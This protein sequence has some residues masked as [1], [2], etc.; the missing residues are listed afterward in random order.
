MPEKKN[1]CLT[2][3]SLSPGGAEKQCLLLAKALKPYH[4]PFVVILK[5][6]PVYKKHLKVIEVEGLNHIFL[7][8]NPIKRAFEFTSFLRKKNIDIIFSF[9]PMDTIWGGIC[10]RAA[11]VPYVFGGIR[12]SYLPWFKSSMLRVIH[13]SLLNYTIANNYAAYNSAI[14][15]GFKNK[16]MVIPNGIKIR[17]LPE[18]KKRDG[19]TIT[20]ISVGRLVK[21]KAYETSIKCIAELKKILNNN[22]KVIYKIVGQGPELANIVATIEKY[23]L[24]GQVEIITDASNVYS[25]LEAS[26]IYLSTTTFEGISNALMEAMN[27]GL[28]MVVTDAG[29]NSLLVR[30][31]HNG[32]LTAIDDF[33]DMARQL[34]HLI[35]NPSMRDQMGLESYRHLVKNFSY[36]AFQDKYLKLI[37][38][39]G[40]IQIHNGDPML[41]NWN[42]LKME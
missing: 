37:T 15:F 14:D 7:A 6:R 13:N 4:N 29:D 16:I 8:H 23:D 41:P 1:I 12:S 18:R 40:S 24:N 34:N 17:P 9:L 28:P 30:N 39:M 36:T 2:I 32:I 27:C 21:S 31:G 11:G 38:H 19:K 20:I 33:K 3:N 26:D 42:S 10:G 22:Q 25:L 35:E 5:P